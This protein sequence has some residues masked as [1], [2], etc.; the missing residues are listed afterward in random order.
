[1]E[2]TMFRSTVPISNTLANNDDSLMLWYGNLYSPHGE[3]LRA[4]FYASKGDFTTAGQI[5]SLIPNFYELSPMWEDVLDDIQ[6]IYTIL[7]SRSIENLTG[8]DLDDLE[9]ISTHPGQASAMAR[10]ILSSQGYHFEPEYYLPEEEEF[11]RPGPPASFV[12][13]SPDLQAYPN[14]ANE[15]LTIE[16]PET[17]FP[18]SVLFELLDATG[19]VILSDKLFSGTNKVELG[20]RLSSG[21]YQYRVSDGKNIL[22]NGVVVIEIDKN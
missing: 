20:K 15:V 21:A 2:Y 5:L 1:M 16:V 22:S 11:V 14:P 12:P 17:L 10:G 6:D 3:V 18:G 19:R 7:S 13:S 4:N 9:E 8:T